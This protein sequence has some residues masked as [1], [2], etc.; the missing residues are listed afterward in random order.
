MTMNFR[1]LEDLSESDIQRAEEIAATI[2][3]EFGDKLKYKWDSLRSASQALAERNNVEASSLY[4]ALQWYLKRSLEEIPSG[5]FEA[6]DH[7]RQVL[8]ESADYNGLAATYLYFLSHPEYGVEL[9]DEDDTLLM[10]KMVQS[11]FGPGACYSESYVQLV[12]SVYG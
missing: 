4:G 9:S 6:E 11:D 8:S 2:K 5:S 3:P 10:L 1:I 7:A 12:S